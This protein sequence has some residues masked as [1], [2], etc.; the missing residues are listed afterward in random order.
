MFVAKAIESLLHGIIVI[1]QRSTVH[2]NILHRRVRNSLFSENK[3]QGRL[4]V[5]HYVLAD[6]LMIPRFFFRS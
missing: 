4:V 5:V 2:Y 3:N 6:G 1:V